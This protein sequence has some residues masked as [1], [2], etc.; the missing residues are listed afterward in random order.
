MAVPGDAYNLLN[1]IEGPDDMKSLAPEQLRQLSAELRQF[2][3]EIV[4]SNPGHF[5]ASLGVVELTVRFAEDAG[6]DYGRDRCAVSLRHQA[7]GNDGSICRYNGSNLRDRFS[8]R[9]GHSAVSHA[10][11]FQVQADLSRLY[12]GV[13]ALSC[14]HI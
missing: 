11:W 4:S 7:G 6:R 1:T 3:I 5:G 12:T 8:L 9:P 14:F 13:R 10:N 2:I